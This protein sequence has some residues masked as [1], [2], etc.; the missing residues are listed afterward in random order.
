MGMTR[1]VPQ[2]SCLACRQVKEK[3]ELLRF[4]LDPDRALLVD[5]QARLPGRGAYTCFRQGCL[6][7]AI[8]RKQFA[9]AFKGPVVHGTVEELTE[10]V[11]FRMTER[12]ASYIALANKAG[13][14]ITGS[15]MVEDAIRKQEVGLVIIATD[16]S[17]DIGEK[18]SR[19]A[20]RVQLPCYRAL[21]KD[22]IGGLVGKGLRSAVAICK[23]GFVQAIG[24]E[25]ERLR[26]FSGEGEQE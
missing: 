18:I 25:I 6:E 19:L 3:G 8:R 20:T 13:K 12:I 2:R 5:L 4:V 11:M 24:N 1:S 15:D 7:D 9:R 26:N 10:L 14:V 23:S 22:R 21:T 17:P 16:V